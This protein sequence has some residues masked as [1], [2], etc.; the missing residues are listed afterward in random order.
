LLTGCPKHEIIPA[1]TPHV[2]LDADFL[3]NVNG[4]VLE[5]TQNVNGYYNDALKTKMILPS[6]APSSAVY[7]AELK[8][9]QSLVAIKV[10]LGSVYFDAS[11]AQDPSLSVWKDFFMANDDPDDPSYSAGAASGF[12]VVY[13]DGTGAVWT[14]DES[15]P[16]TVKF[17]N[18]VQESDDTGDYMKFT[19]TFDCNVYRDVPDTSTPDPNDTITISLPIA[20]A[21]FN[22]YFKR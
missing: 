2:D 14:S 5:L 17:T 19:C 22:G 9:S 6:P 18:V 3:G 11:A 15:S 7:S 10:N 12:E 20:D 21:V 16:G 13:R 1:P 8:S 4:S